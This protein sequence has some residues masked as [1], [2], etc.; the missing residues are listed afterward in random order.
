VHSLLMVDETLDAATPYSGSLVVRKLFPNASL[1]A[2]PGGTS[3]ANSFSGD[4]CLDD[5]IAL[6]MAN[7][8]L[9]PRKPGNHA[10]TTC[11][12]LPQPDPTAATAQAQAKAAP[13]TAGTIDLRR[14]LQLAVTRP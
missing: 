1:I 7:G 13:A 9:P 3:H 10:D 8:T 5:Q 4:A 6:Y 12:P 2:L 11:A 14:T